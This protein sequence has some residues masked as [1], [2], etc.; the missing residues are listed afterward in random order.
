MNLPDQFQHLFHQK[1]ETKETYLSLAFL[2][3]F[4]VASAWTIGE[5]HDL[6]TLACES[7]PIKDTSWEAKLDASDAVITRIEEKMPQINLSQVVFGFSAEFLTEEGD[8]QKSIRPDLKKLTTM[9]E[10]KPAGF[11][12][13]D[14]AIIFQL[15]HDEGV[16]PS[17]IMLYIH[18]SEIAVSLYRVGTIV[19]SREI[20]AGEFVVQDVEDAIKS[21]SDVEILPS[22]MILYGQDDDTLQTLKSKLLMHQWPSRANFL[23]YPKIDIMTLPDIAHAVTMAGASELTSVIPTE[24]HDMTDEQDSSDEEIS[25]ATPSTITVTED[26]MHAEETELADENEKTEEKEEVPLYAMAH[27]EKMKDTEKEDT[28]HADDEETSKEEH[29]A[30]S[31]HDMNVIPVSPDVVGFHQQGVRVTAQ[32]RYEPE[33]VPKKKFSLPITPFVTAIGDRIQDIKGMMAHGHP[34]GSVTPRIPI[35]PIVIILLLIIGGV[36]GYMWFIPHATVTLSVIQKTIDKQQSAT[37]S[38]TAT[39]VDGAKFI[40]PGKKQEKSVSGEKTL[41]VT[42]KKRIGDPARGTVTLYN[43]DTATVTLKKGAVIASGSLQFTLDAD[44]SIASASESIGSITFGKADAAVTAS[45]IG[46]EGNLPSGTE[47]SVKTYAV[48]DLVARNDAAFAGGK[49]R[50]AT[51]VTRADQDALVKALSDELVTQAK[52]DLSTS[53]A[54]GE[55][56]I[57]QTVTTTVTSKTFTEELDQETNQLHGKITIT[58]SGISYSENDVKQLLLSLA[59]QEVPAGYVVNEGRTTT[60]VDNPVVKKDGTITA[61]AKIHLSSIPSIDAKKFQAQL[62]GKSIVQA[63]GIIKATQGIGSA[64]FTFKPSGKKSK[65]PINAANITVEVVVSD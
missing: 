28:E 30:F 1:K 49:S 17:A 40:I 6:T 32:E 39:A 50:Q 2:H 26:V 20:K 47:F 11:V 42:G 57:D 46:E 38:T 43:K 58:V 51:V 21:F 44:V 10:L 37:I 12:G 54:G 52:T 9:L 4:V 22:R 62:A 56:L 5:E 33:E 36:A 34:E 48:S 64:E 65:L 35:I 53:V 14:A 7:L 60:T 27:E 29:V 8:I 63:E 24:D 41:A 25:V 13:I 59:S 31:Q 45:S 16:P 55:K 61:L 15:K 19:G 18:D 23:H 3:S